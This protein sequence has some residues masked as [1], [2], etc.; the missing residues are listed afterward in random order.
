MKIKNLLARVL[1]FYSQEDY[2]S[3]YK[4]LRE[5][6]PGTEHGRAD[7]ELTITLGQVINSSGPVYTVALGLWWYLTGF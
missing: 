1:W 2:T 3:T 6:Q 4:V 5:L 7:K